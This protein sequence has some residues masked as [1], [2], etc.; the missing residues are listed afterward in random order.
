VLVVHECVD[1][2]TT[3]PV[4]FGILI[5]RTVCLVALLSEA[6]PELAS[7]SFGERQSTYP[8]AGFWASS[9]GVGAG[10]FG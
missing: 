4:D 8:I 2:I 3:L 6:T 1:S 5:I 10:V 7:S 9:S